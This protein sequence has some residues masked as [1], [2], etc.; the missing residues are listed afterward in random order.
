MGN[1]VVCRWELDSVDCLWEKWWSCQLVNCVVG[2]VDEDGWS[3]EVGNVN[4][5][6]VWF[7]DCRVVGISVGSK[8]GR[9]VGVIV[10]EVVGGMR[11]WF[12][13]TIVG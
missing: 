11:C 7:H 6:F 5:V 2:L 4:G 3:L 8:I 12:V 9:F 1:W 13:G 10:G